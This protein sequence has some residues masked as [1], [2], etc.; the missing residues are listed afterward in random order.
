MLFAECG[1]FCALQACCEGVQ[2]EIVMPEI[3]IFDSSTSIIT[4]D[5]KSCGSVPSQGGLS[6]SFFARYAL[7]HSLRRPRRRARP[8]V[9][10]LTK[11]V[12]LQLGGTPTRLRCTCLRTGGSLT[13]TCSTG[14]FGVVVFSVSPPF[15]STLSAP[16]Q[17]RNRGVRGWRWSVADI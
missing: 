16:I 8:V 15:S 7:L 4:L 11:A 10:F 3:D 5:L 17:L 6:L 9:H 13:A 1:P 14:P 2:V 12:A